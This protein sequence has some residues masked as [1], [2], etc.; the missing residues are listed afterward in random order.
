VIYLPIHLKTTLQTPTL[1]NGMVLAAQAMGA[2]VA[3]ALIANRL[4]QRLGS[5]RA[6]CSGLG[7]LAIAAAAFPHLH[8]L[9]WFFPVAVLF[10]VGLGIAVPNHYAVLANLAPAELQASV[11]ATATGMNFLG[12]FLSPLL[13]GLVLQQAELNLVFYAA[14]GLAIATGMAL[15]M[16]ERQWE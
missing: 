8:L 6:I 1:T 16:A 10:G 15:M 3:S 5:S 9:V 14:S 7:C 11:L 12:Q 2:A 13:F 4:A